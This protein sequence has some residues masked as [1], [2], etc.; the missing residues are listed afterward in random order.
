MGSGRREL[1]LIRSV[2]DAAIQVYQKKKKGGVFTIMNAP[3][4]PHGQNHIGIFYNQVLK[5]IILRYHLIDGKKVKNILGINCF[6]DQLE[7]WSAEFYKEIQSLEKIRLEVEEGIRNPK[8]EKIDA[9][10]VY[11]NYLKTQ[12]ETHLRELYRW[13]VLLDPKDV[14]L[15][16]SSDYAKIVYE[17]LSEVAA[18]I[19]LDFTAHF[20]AFKSGYRYVPIQELEIGEE[21]RERNF[22]TY[23]MDSFQESRFELMLSLY[24]RLKFIAFT[25]DPWKLAGTRAIAL[26]PNCDYLVFVHNLEF[27]C[28]SNDCFVKYKRDLFPEGKEPKA[29]KTFFAGDLLGLR[30]KNP[31]H[32]AERIP[33]VLNPDL[34][35]EVC[36]TMLHPFSP[37]SDAR[38]FSLSTDFL[39]DKR[40]ILDEFGKLIHPNEKLNG[41][42]IRDR[43]ADEGV[44]LLLASKNSIINF[45]QHV[46]IIYTRDSK[47]KEEIYLRAAIDW[48]VKPNTKLAKTLAREISLIETGNT[49]VENNI[50]IPTKTRLSDLFDSQLKSVLLSSKQSFGLPAPIFRF[51]SE[52]SRYLISKSVISHVAGLIARHGPG[53]WEN[54]S[55]DD[56]LPEKYKHLA[57]QLDKVNFKISSG[58]MNACCFLKTREM[59]SGNQ[60][61]VDAIL[62]GS[63]MTNNWMYDTFALSLSHSGVIPPTKSLYSHSL[64]FP[65]EGSMK[66]SKSHEGYKMHDIIEGQV[67][68]T[69]ERH[70]GN[71]IEHLRLWAASINNLQSG[72]EVLTVSPDDVSIKLAEVNLVRDAFSYIVNFMNRHKPE[73]KDYESLSRFDRI[74]A[75][76]VDLLD[77]FITDAYKKGD[78]SEVY[79]LSMDFL[80]S[81]F[82]DFIYPYLINLEKEGGDKNIRRARYVME[83]I[84]NISLKS[85]APILPFTCEEASFRA[86]GISVFATT[87]PKIV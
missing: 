25:D 31:L 68:V 4:S 71:G 29:L 84:L 46:N 50:S 74:I 19:H 51:R 54:W 85:L 39:F 26:H 53:V 44:I 57:D 30:L 22:V 41:L 34:D 66:I 27:Y 81:H 16:N 37:G 6:G 7:H 61:P 65:E 64:I 17:V 45:K 8:I 32:E 13:G 80:K 38:D 2:N 12:I 28:M 48:R 83:L 63:S 58:F 36:P 1:E 9:F 69:G 87:F 59:V 86:K 23:E 3:Y 77:Q 11:Q 10:S 62:E 15:T 35:K 79:Y 18:D 73:D 42:P 49:K 47:T 55:V 67:K 82:M 33:F 21:Y 72:V 43:L 24:P 14:Y 5:D 52:D 40:P 56:L 70:Y 78:T 76:N 60:Y 20:Y 75:S